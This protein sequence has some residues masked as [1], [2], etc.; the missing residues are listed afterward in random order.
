ML[1]SDERRED[2]RPVQCA[3]VVVL[4]LELAEVLQVG[5]RVW[6]YVG[7]VAGREFEIL[8]VGEVVEGSGLDMPEGIVR[9]VELIEIGR[10]VEKL[11]VEIPNAACIKVEVEQRPAIKEVILDLL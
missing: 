4:Y 7:Q 5:E 11:G 10:V 2:V 6:R 8:E 9:E 1:E 3:H